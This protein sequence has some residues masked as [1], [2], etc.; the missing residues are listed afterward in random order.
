[1]AQ[2][3][4]PKFTC[5][6]KSVFTFAFIVL[7]KTGY[8]VE[9]GQQYEKLQSCNSLHSFKL[10]TSKLFLFFIHGPKAMVECKGLK[11]TAIIK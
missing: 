11:N 1:M 2:H 6:S 8:Q 3:L 5:N 7:V 9:Y 10:L 4:K